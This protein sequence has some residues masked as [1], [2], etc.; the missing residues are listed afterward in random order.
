MKFACLYRRIDHHIIQNTYSVQQRAH[1]R[2]I[3]AVKGTR[4]LYMV[5]SEYD[6]KINFL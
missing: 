2:N 1:I 3:W 4:P 6:R 5:D